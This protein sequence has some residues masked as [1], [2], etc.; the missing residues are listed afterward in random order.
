[1]NDELFERFWCAGMRKSNKKKAKIAFN[2]T[3]KSISNKEAFVDSLIVDIRE[4]LQLDQ[5]GFKNMLPTTYLNGERWEDEKVR[6]NSAGVVPR[7]TPAERS[8]EQAQKAIAIAERA[9]NQ[10]G[11]SYVDKNVAAIP[12]QMDIP[13]G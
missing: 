4:R 8:Y 11:F 6:R 2:R 13:R 3:L 5:L 1:M 7:Q 12:Q 9:S 10:T